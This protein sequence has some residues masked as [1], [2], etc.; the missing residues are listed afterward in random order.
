MFGKTY[1][2]MPLSYQ[3]VPAPQWNKNG[4]LPIGRE[5]DKLCS[6]KCYNAVVLLGNIDK[7]AAGAAMGGSKGKGIGKTPL[8]AV[9]SDCSKGGRSPA[10]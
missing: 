3:N 8:A 5:T 7:G 9:H 4:H 1:I 10:D 2:K 6:K